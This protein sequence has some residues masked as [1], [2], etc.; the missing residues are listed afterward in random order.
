[1]V[2]WNGLLKWSL[3]HSDGTKKS[4][5]KEMNAETKKWLQDAM[6]SYSLNEVAFIIIQIKE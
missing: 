3:T 5:F 6:E 1:M 2:D 4:D